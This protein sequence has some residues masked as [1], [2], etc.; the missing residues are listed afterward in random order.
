MLSIRL[1]LVLAA[2]LAPLVAAVPAARMAGCAASTGHHGHHGE[3]PGVPSSAGDGCCLIAPCGATWRPGA[4]LRLPV[5][6]PTRDLDVATLVPHDF[7]RSS[8]SRRQPPATAPP[9]IA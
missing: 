2:V 3:A 5:S 6:A 9:A 1:R 8:T 7:P 4:A